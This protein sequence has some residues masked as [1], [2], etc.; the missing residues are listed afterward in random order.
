M[1][2]ADLFVTATS[3]LDYKDR[4]RD[5]NNPLRLLTENEVYRLLVWGNPTGDPKKWV[6]HSVTYEKSQTE[7]VLWS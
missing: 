3:L 2:P 7:V 6:D 4:I 1:F 5:M